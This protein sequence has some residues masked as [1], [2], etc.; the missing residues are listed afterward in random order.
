MLHDGAAA[1]HGAA[2]A[3]RALH[4]DGC[5]HGWCIAR[6][7]RATC[8]NRPPW[9][10]PRSYMHA[11]LGQKMKLV[12]KLLKQQQPV[13]GSIEMHNTFCAHTIILE[14]IPSCRMASI[15]CLMLEILLSVNL[16]H[17][18]QNI[19][20]ML[21]LCTMLESHAISRDA[22]LQR[23]E[24]QLIDFSSAFPRPAPR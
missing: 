14:R 10:R 12:L 15:R 23:Q 7:A 22:C 24:Q 20:Y 18:D 8:H 17:A 6:I 3:R 13:V 4:A 9:S 2:A 19:C 21:V 1:S 5:M 11:K 16:M